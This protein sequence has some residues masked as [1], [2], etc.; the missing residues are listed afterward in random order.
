[1]AAKESTPNRRFVV[2]GKVLKSDKHS[3]S[4]KVIIIH[5]G[6]IKASELWVSKP[7]I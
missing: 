7:K 5:P 6:Q 3:D 4:Y 2:G 1:M